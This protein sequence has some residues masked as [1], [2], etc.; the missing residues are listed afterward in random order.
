MSTVSRLWRRAP[1]WRFFLYACGFFLVLG[2]IFPTPF[3]TRHTGWVHAL[4]RHLPSFGSPSGE[5]ASNSASPDAPA[6]NGVGGQ[7]SDPMDSPRIT[8][9]DISKA[10]AGAVPFGGHSLPLPDGVWH[11]VLDGQYGL[12]GRMS[13]IVLARTDR[14]IVT[15]IMIASSTNQ[16]VPRDVVE[17]AYN[18]CHDDRNYHST[19]LAEHPDGQTECTFITSAYMGPSG[20]ITND[21]LVQL[22]FKRL[23]TLGFPMP[24]LFVLGS[25]LYNHGASDSAKGATYVSLLLAPTQPGTVALRAPLPYW[26][27][28]MISRSAP[29]LDFVRRVDIWFTDWAS[30]LRQGM[31]NDYTGKTPDTRLARDPAAPQ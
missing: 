10:I 30:V 29:A 1:A 4:T 26:D 27:K 7:N 22:A 8:T 18:R 25:W 2:L 24:S 3:V 5:E 16:D 9:P 23:T 14:G 19:V 21:P 6:Q 12:D 31:L 17:D 13:L 11:P 15:G 20:A 28:R